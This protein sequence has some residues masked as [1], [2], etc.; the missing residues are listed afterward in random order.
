MTNIFNF[1]LLCIYLL[2][3]YCASED[4]ITVHLVTHT[5]D[6]PGWLKT[7]D[8]YFHGSNNT[9]YFAGVQYILDTVVQI[10]SDDK[11]K[12]FSYAEMSFFTMWY[13]RLC[14]KRKEIVK[15]LVRR[16][17]LSFMNGGWCMHDEASSHYLSMIDQTSLGHAFLKEEFDFVPTVGWQIDPFGHSST[18][19]WLLSA[20][21]GFDGLFFGRIDY[22]DRQ[23]RLA[24]KDMEM[25]WR[26]SESMS[27]SE[28]FTGAF[29]SGNYGPPEG[30]CFDA[31][32]TDEPVVD[33]A[34][35]SE[36]NMDSKILAFLDAVKVEHSHARGR[37]IMLKMGSD[38]HYTNAHMWFS[39]LDKIINRVNKMNVGVEVIY[40][41]PVEYLT[42]KSKENVTWSLKTDDFF[43]YADCA[44][45]Y[46][47]GYFTSRPTLKYLERQGSGFLQA[48]RQLQ[49]LAT[50]SHHPPPPPPLTALASD[51][52]KSIQSL[53]Q[54]V[55]LANHHDAVTGTSK[56]HVADD[57][58]RI[59]SAAL[60]QAEDFASDIV[61]AIG[62]H[63][64]LPPGSL[65]VCRLVNES[66]CTL[67]QTMSMGDRVTVIVY[68]SLSRP[69]SHQVTLILPQAAAEGYV[70][71]RDLDADWVPSQLVPTVSTGSGI[72]SDSDSTSWT[73]IF[74]AKVLD[75]LE[76]ARFVVHIT[77][78]PPSRSVTAEVTLE[79]EIALS[80]E[81]ID[82]EVEFSN[83]LVSITIDKRTGLLSGVRRLDGG[84]SG[85]NVDIE[86]HQDLHYY[87]SFVASEQAHR[88]LNR[89]SRDP[90]LK[91]IQ[92][93]ISLTGNDSQQSSGAYVFRPST[94]TPTPVRDSLSQESI[95]RVTVV[96]GEE[97]IE[98]RQIFSSWA[99]QIIRLRSSSSAVEIEWTIGPIPLDCDCDGKEVISRF[100]SSVDSGN[101]F[102]T[103][104]NGKEFLK[105]I[106]DKRPTWDWDVSEPV[107]GNYYPITQ[108]IYIKSATAQLTILTDRSQG[109]A[110]LLSGQV[111][112]M[113]HRRLQTD[114]HRGVDEALNETTE[115]MSHF[116][117]WERKGPG[118]RVTG[119]H[120]LLL[121]P[122][123]V[124]MK[125]TRE[126]M[127]TLLWSP[128]TFLGRNRHEVD[129][130]VGFRDVS[131]GKFVAAPPPLRMPLPP[132]L[133][134]V[135]LQL[136]SPK[137]ILLR[138][139]NQ[140]AKGE[141][142]NRVIHIDLQD[143]LLPL[144]D[145]I[146][147]E[148]LSLSANQNKFEMINRKVRWN[149]QNGTTQSPD[150][151][152]PLP[153]GVMPLDDTPI[154]IDILPMEIRTFRIILS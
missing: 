11:R 18:N 121:S 117:G 115:G 94:P 118:I 101:E 70:T 138:L 102:Y 45:C 79:S 29:T 82:A 83:E 105:R 4:T 60:S 137:N 13:D 72:P 44:H 135:S 111:E 39:N 16:R 75:P 22:Q 81:G 98:V 77:D 71:V 76:F 126:F 140:L 40:S 113:I 130:S 108:G 84:D 19:A 73:L 34:A 61:A 49:V 58:V 125:E 63:P 32:C 25:V 41:T 93:H 15:D 50:V 143:L 3:C 124:A 120:F 48:V 142:G 95:L 57:Y 64:P 132:H 33:N 10:L 86:V 106:R 59:L 103:D 112:L 123:H 154:L 35:S 52:S 6:D 122:V 129:T 145:A 116:P 27:E 89:D 100:E 99:S 30:F 53:A 31:K 80:P 37:H 9:I 7:M 14:S 12:K 65:S 133:Q 148:E 149:L 8:Q 21:V 141:I 146:G 92:P 119:R 23:K 114:D 36:Y 96:Q 85:A 68:N 1:K 47:T 107:A 42:A 153:A 56:Q 110:S 24:S 5:H 131:V 152:T 136:M 2:A 69:R 87:S 78:S 127:D 28:V 43:P 104:S 74:T 139:G 90:H 55:G 150:R 54:A 151:R 109:A 134:V 88:S 62:V 91:N 147:V 20:E 38:F 17:Q 67:T 51:P 26:G 66:V 97:V 46:W 144:D 128:V